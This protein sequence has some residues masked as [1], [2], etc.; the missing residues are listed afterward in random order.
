M[1]FVP[2]GMKMG[3]RFLK[4]HFE[5]GLAKKKMGGS[6]K[7]QSVTIEA[8]DP[9]SLKSSSEKILIKLG[10]LERQPT[11]ERKK[12]APV[13]KQSGLLVPNEKAN[14]VRLHQKSI[15]LQTKEKRPDALWLI[16][17]APSFNRNQCL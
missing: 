7:P 6:T 11:A 3:L 17:N 5:N 8:K 1:E 16:A 15:D 10:F 13:Q 4:Y 12:R 9:T 2:S 14:A